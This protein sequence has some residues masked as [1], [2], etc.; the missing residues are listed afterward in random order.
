MALILAIIASCLAHAYDLS[1]NLPCI[2]LLS[3]P[4]TLDFFLPSL[5]FF[6]VD[7]HA[8]G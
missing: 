4:Y 3:K 1:I 2:L 7:Q 8:V 6:I 5:M